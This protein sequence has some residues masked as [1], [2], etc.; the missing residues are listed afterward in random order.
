MIISEVEIS[1]ETKHNK[2]HFL[3]LKVKSVIW[4][5]LSRKGQANTHVHIQNK[6]VNILPPTSMKCFAAK[7]ERGAEKQKKEKLASLQGEG[8]YW[9]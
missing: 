3:F 7:P 8:W 1:K 9:M 4:L 2:N 5:L 6:N